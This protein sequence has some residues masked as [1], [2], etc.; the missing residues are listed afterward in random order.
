MR[1][2]LACFTLDL[3]PDL[4][5]DDSHEILLDSD[6]FGQFETFILRNQ[7][8][9][10]VFVVG[11]MLESGLPIRERFANFGAEFELHSYSHNAIEPDS[12]AEIVQGRE[13][14]LNYFGHPPRGYRAP[15]GD[16]SYRGLQ[17]L[18]REGFCY[19]ASVFP[20]WRPELGYNY[21]GLPT[22]PWVFAEFP[23]LV[24]L[25]FAVVPTVRAVI[26][27]SFLKL[28]GFRFYRLMFYAFGFPEII[29]FDSHLH[30]FFVPQTISSRPRLDWRRHA[31]MR[32]QN[33]SLRLVQEF[34]D[35]LKDRGYVFVSMYELYKGLIRSA[36]T[37]PTVSASILRDSVTSASP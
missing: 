12:E 23:N 8:R 22:R 16:I 11:K 32:N 21:R 31:L 25:P 14:Y 29:I 5:V 35:F 10:T 2:R 34:I 26:S 7:L 28:L 17:V 30:D 1:Q 36:Q 19:D 4:Y 3:E 33:D 13:A 6:R 15:N 20:A 27:M 37:L 9:M 18:S 24:E